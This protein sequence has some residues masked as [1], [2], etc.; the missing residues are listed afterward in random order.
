VTAPRATLN[1]SA[2][3]TLATVNGVVTGSVSLGPQASAGPANWQVD[4][5]ILQTSRPGVAPIPRCQVYLDTVQ[6]GSSQGLTYDGSF[7]QGRTDIRVARG[8]QLIAV[9]TGGT[10]GDVASMTVTGVKY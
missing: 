3:T 4:G 5:V 2:S 1:M 6:P 7:D 9:W 8:S 10:A